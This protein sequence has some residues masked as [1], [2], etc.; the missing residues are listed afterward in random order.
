M[1]EHLGKAIDGDSTNNSLEHAQDPVGLWRCCKC[2]KG[3]D[4]YQYDQ[5]PH[6]VSGLNCD[7]THRSCEDCMLTGGI[8][9]YKPVYEPFP[10]QLDDKDKRVLFG[11]F[12]GYCGLS[13]QAQIT[14]YMQDTVRQKIA[15]VPK[16]LAKHGT[17]PL[18]KLRSSRS[19]TN[20]LGQPTPKAHSLK[21]N[22]STL[23]LRALSNEME[24]EYGKQASL[25]MVKFSGIVCTCGWTLDT[26]ALCFQIVDQQK[27]K[28]VESPA[29]VGKQA[30]FT[31]TAEDKEK[32][33]ETPTIT[34]RPGGKKIRHANP[35]RSAP[36]TDE[37][38][39]RLYGG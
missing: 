38:M 3:H 5:R 11:I 27:K 15:A 9:A 32:G 29:T 30:T 36:V 25:V 10:V 16:N 14:G 28:A 34:L 23:N 37:E 20:L 22:K 39:A 24:K 19:M 31:A 1:L 6:L 18:E 4:L 35:L 26:S 17:H 7:C 21:A 12:C 8:K 13:W 33:I 2:V